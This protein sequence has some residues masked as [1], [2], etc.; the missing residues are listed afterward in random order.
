MAAAPATAVGSDVG[1]LVLVA[2]VPGCTVGGGGGPALLPE[3]PAA[4]ARTTPARTTAT[5]AMTT[6]LNGPLR[7]G[8]IRRIAQT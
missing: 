5:T 4:R 3:H 2:A 6:V 7:A 1:V 8:E